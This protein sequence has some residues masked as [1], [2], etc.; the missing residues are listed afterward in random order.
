MAARILASLIPGTSGA[1][2]TA[3]FSGSQ[4][5]QA[6]ERA[7]EITL[8][9]GTSASIVEVSDDETPGVWR[10]SGTAI[11]PSGLTHFASPPACRAIRV[12]GQA[13]AAVP[14]VICLVRHGL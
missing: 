8:Y 7:T 2:F 13:P 12:A 5:K 11:A 1:N 6:L 14:P 3:E 10:A 9:G 4:N